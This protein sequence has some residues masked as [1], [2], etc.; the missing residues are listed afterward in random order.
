MID[1][2]GWNYSRSPFENG[3]DMRKLCTLLNADGMVWVGIR[4]WSE[5]A[6]QWFNNSE[7]ETVRVLAW[8][9]LPQP[10][11]QRWTRGT[12]L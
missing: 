8:M 9:D 12:L 2:Q 3:K 11:A 7:P 4:I 1:Q 10:A 5:P 6:Q